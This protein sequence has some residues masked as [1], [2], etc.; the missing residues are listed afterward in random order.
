MTDQA[1]EMPIS[2]IVGTLLP[3]LRRYARALT[4]SQKTGDAYAAATLESIISDRSVFDG[5]SSPKVALFR[6]FHAIWKSA[7]APVEGKESG[8]AARAQAHL[9]RL[10]PNTREALLL[11]SIEEFTATEIG[12]IMEAGR[13]EVLHFLA[14]ARR[15]IEESLSGRILVIEDEAIIALDLQS[16][17]ADM[18]HAITGVARTHDGA[19]ALAKKE[20]PDL[21]LSDI[22][23][24]DGSSGIEAVNEIL[25][26]AGDIP[27]VF[28]TAFPERLLTGDRPEPAFVIT[29]P[30]SE[31][32][33]QVA[34][35]QAMFFAST[36]TLQ[37]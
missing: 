30:Y 19:V 10:T 18:G 21:I 28:I 13:D 1:D 6:V 36:E 34:V 29:K 35:S 27:V 11:S 8:I 15:E 22:Q 3:Y 17:V 37:A 31:K 5:Q 23:L 14:V 33:I 4:G 25:K 24:A 20:R 16:I 12:E 9:E 26:A 2:E 7:G 32:Q